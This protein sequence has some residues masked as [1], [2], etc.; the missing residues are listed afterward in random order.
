[1]D[2]TA[3]EGRLRGWL[4]PQPRQAGQPS[5]AAGTDPAPEPPQLQVTAWGWGIAVLGEA[6]RKGK[7]D[8]GANPWPLANPAYGLPGWG[9]GELPRVHPLSALK[10]RSPTPT[11]AHQ[12]LC[13]PAHAASQVTIP[14][15]VWETW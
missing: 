7:G 10:F 9:V 8:I 5:P 3:G 14:V 13:F 15:P 12:F 1:M 11:C 4:H 6:N 2:W